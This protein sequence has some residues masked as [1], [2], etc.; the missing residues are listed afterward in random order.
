MYLDMTAG[1][2][3]NRTKLPSD[4]GWSCVGVSGD[5]SDQ[6]MEIPRNE[7]FAHRL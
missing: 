4:R 5:L 1:V 7:L 2:F 3:Y 6:D